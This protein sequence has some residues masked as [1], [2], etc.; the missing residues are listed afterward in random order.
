M[1]G[2]RRGI[3]ARKSGF[4]GLQPRGFS[5]ISHGWVRNAPEPGMDLQR[6]FWKAKA[7]FFFCRAVKETRSCEGSRDGFASAEIR[8]GSKS[9]KFLTWKRGGGCGP[10]STVAE[11]GAS[12]RRVCA[13]PRVPLLRKGLGCPPQIQ[14]RGN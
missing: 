13:Q 4:L 7:D 6:G 12:A 8:R 14:S 11:Q 10:P 5:I 1:T 9:H 3:L 2:C